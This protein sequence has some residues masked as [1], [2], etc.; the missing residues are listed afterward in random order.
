MKNRRWKIADWE[1]K[2]RRI[3]DC[4]EENEGDVGKT[5]DD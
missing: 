1:E 2:G 5:I 3:D 4:R